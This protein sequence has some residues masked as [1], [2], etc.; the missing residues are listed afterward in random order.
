[1]DIGHWTFLRTFLIA[2]LLF[3]AVLPPGVG[4]A[5]KRLH[6]VI[7]G[8]TDLHGNIFPLDYY[9][10]KPD[11]R[12]LAKI[13]TIIKQARQE[14]KNVLLID[15]GD[16]IQGTPLE[17]Y[18]NKK[19]NQPTDPMMLAMNALQYDAMAVGNHEYNFGLQVL[20]KARSE[21]KFP[22]LS[23]NTYNK[24]TN[25]THYAPYL[26]KEI[27]GVRI[28]VLGLTTP[29]V[30]T[31]ENLPNYAGLEFHDPL[32]EAK[33]WVPVL[34][35]KE[36]A[37]V[38][39]I[40]MHM[41]LEQDLRTG[42]EN[43]GQVQNE[44]RA[45]A[46]AREVPGV[47][48]IFMGHTHRDNPS[49]VINGVQLIQANYWGRHLA[50]VDLYLEDDAKGWRIYAR[51]A[52]TIAMND[53]IAPDQEILTLAEPYN[54][55]TQAW[56]SRAIGESAKQL[57][58]S[59]ARFSDTAILDLIQRVQLEAGKADVSMAAVFNPEAR[60][61]NGAVTVRDIAGLYVYENTLVVLEVTGQQ[62]K[63]ALEHSAKYFR[64]HEAGKTPADLVDEK[65][66]AYN[67]DI[68]EGVSY[69]LNLTKPI[70]QR[71]EQLEFQGKPL[72]PTQKLRLATN[73]YR[74]NGGGGYT[75]YKGAPVVYRSSVEIRELI[76][77]WVERHKKIPT[78][79]TNNWK[80]IF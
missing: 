66:P 14:N 74:V 22:W 23:A 50:R 12:G 11:N 5:A 43:P 46:I 80:I 62:L 44:N 78:E 79:P 35:N 48:L 42:E 21:A 13:A 24:G 31:W 16:T 58:A 64:A 29:G 27:G 7:L 47:D 36:H 67:F 55:E 20:E 72:A 6:V 61:A 18:H 2:V 34:R 15:S 49:V 32:L 25:E 54:R 69:V 53:A 3:L 73:N 38:V 1:M 60:I 76:I 28:G 30:P 8:T 17:Y 51:G 75:M 68:A 63:D 71:I 41:G 33:K 10:D 56:L 52:R 65:I 77:D 37:D 45:I 40:A 57:T 59:E 26:V 70:G 39:V 19:N 4:S 9:T